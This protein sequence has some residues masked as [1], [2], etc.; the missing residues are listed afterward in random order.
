M[1]LRSIYVL[2]FALVTTNSI[3]AQ[4]FKPGLIGGLSVTDIVGVDPWDEDYHKIGFVAGGL[5]ATNLSEKNSL[6][7][8]LLYTQKG[9]L[10]PRDSS[11][12]F[13]YLKISLD[14]LEVPLLFKHTFKFSIY[15]KPVNGCYFEI[16]PSVGRLIRTRV[17]SDYYIFKEGN[18][19]K[20]EVALNLGIGYKFTDKLSFNVRYTNSI[21][22]VVNHPLLVSH[23]FWRTFNKGDNVVF[24]FT[25]RY[26]IL[27]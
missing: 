6:Q 27:K 4:R 19:R 2:L 5:I 10:Q 7:L 20:N 1:N 21:I 12:N 26:M 3:Y 15:G 9:S 11:T 22:P 8:E 17:N 18:F 16:G 13:T 25:L 23:Y 14:Y 24:S